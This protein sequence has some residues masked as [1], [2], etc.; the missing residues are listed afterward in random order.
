[1]KTDLQYRRPSGTPT[2]FCWLSTDDT[3][4]I[5]LSSDHCVYPPNQTPHTMITQLYAI[6][7][8]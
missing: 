2:E 5:S 8:R 1:M 3:V 6:Y 7:R 4:R